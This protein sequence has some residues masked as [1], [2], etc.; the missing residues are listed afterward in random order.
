M[1]L[2]RPPGAH[3]HLFVWRLGADLVPSHHLN[4]SAILTLLLS[5]E[6]YGQIRSILWLLM[7]W[8][9]TSPDHQQQW[10]WFRR[11]NGSLSFKW[12]DFNYLHNLPIHQWIQMQLLI[13][14][15]NRK[16]QDPN[17]NFKIFIVWTCCHI[18]TLYNDNYSWYQPFQFG[19]SHGTS[20]LL[21]V[22]P[23][24]PYNI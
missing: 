11:I 3:K 16:S 8:L 2:K 7:A 18:W 4:P 17:N 22:Y 19:F 15:Q 1:F 23:Q 20:T 14:T 10:Y 5:L 13:D 9:S 12:M 6:Y 21:S 24:I